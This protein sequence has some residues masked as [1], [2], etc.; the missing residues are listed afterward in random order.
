ML[1]YDI[2]EFTEIINVKSS[3]I[4][5]TSNFIKKMFYNQKLSRISHSSVRETKYQIYLVAVTSQD[6]FHLHICFSNGSYRHSRRALVSFICTFSFQI[7]KHKG[8]SQLTQW[9]MQI[10]DKQK[11]LFSRH[12]VVKN[13][14]S[15]GTEISFEKMATNRTFLSWTI[16]LCNL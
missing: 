7:C 5:Q 3:R 1:S 12:K 14:S 15:Y 4:L 8:R 2:N 10:Q 16:R 11:I 9:C 13:V 6:Q